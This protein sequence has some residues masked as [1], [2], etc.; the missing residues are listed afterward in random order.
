MTVD[1][2]VSPDDGTTWYTI[3]SFAAKTA[4]GRDVLRVTSPI[5]ELARLNWTIS[6]TTPSFTFSIDAEFAVKGV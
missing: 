1:Y 4:T 3:A 2:Q 5:G 6:G